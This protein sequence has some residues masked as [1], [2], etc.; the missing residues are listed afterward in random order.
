MKI[1]IRD[2]ELLDEYLERFGPGQK[3]F[4]K[5]SMDSEASLLERG[6]RLNPSEPKDNRQA[7]D[8]ICEIG[9]NMRAHLD[10]LSARKQ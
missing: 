4:Q 3:A 7:S 9:K 5:I 6:S 10:Q 2:E 1:R 8:L